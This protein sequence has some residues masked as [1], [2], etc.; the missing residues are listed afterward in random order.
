M[1]WTEEEK[2]RLF[3]YHQLYGNSWM[4]ISR[5][6]PDRSENAIKNFFNITVKKAV[7]EFNLRAS[8]DQQIHLPIKAIIRDKNI[9]LTLG[10]Y[11]GVPAEDNSVQEAE[12]QLT[13]DSFQ[14][15]LV[16]GLQELLESLNKIHSYLLSSL[17]QQ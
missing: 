11:V 14:E 16:K 15:G 5:F 12:L 8:E 7:K 1:E 13:Y 2:Q 9:T 10:M 3:Y 4:R 17:I 6:L